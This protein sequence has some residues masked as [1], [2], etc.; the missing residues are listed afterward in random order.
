MI[1]EKDY[2]KTL[3][4]YQEMGVNMEKY[5]ESLGRRLGLKSVWDGRVP[6]APRVQEEAAVREIE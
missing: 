4:N 6:L 5:C 2:L 3:E 1:N